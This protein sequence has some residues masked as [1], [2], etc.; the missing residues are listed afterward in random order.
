[1]CGVLELGCWICGYDDFLLR[2]AAD[3]DFVHSLFDKLLDI[4]LV[5]AEQYYSVLGPYIDLTTSGDDFGSQNGPLLSPAMFESLIA[6]Y[7]S[8]RIKRTKEL[9][10]CYFWHH[11]CGSVVELL[12]QIIGN[13]SRFHD[14]ETDCPII[15][16]M[17][18]DLQQLSK[19]QLIALVRELLKRIDQLEKRVT[20]LEAENARLKKNSSNSSKPPSSDIVKPKTVKSHCKRKRKRGGQFG[21]RRHVRAAFGS[22]Q[23]DEVIEYELE[24]TTGLRPLNDWRVIQQIELVDRPFVVTEHRARR[25][26]C[27]RTGKIIRATLPAEVV[28]AGLL[29]PRLSAL[30]AYQKGACHM[31]YSTIQTFLRDVFSISVSTGQLAKLMHKA[32]RALA[33]GYQELADALPDEPHVGADETG[34]KDNGRGLW[35]WCFRPGEFTLFKIAASRGSDVLKAVLGETF[36]GV[37]G[38]DYFSAYRKYMADAGATVQFCLAHLIREVRF[39]TTQADK[40]L[41]NWGQKL[42]TELR[43]LFATLHRRAQMTTKGFAQ[44]MDRI[45]RQFLRLVRRPPDRLEARPLARRFRKHGNSYFTFLTTP[46]AEPTNNLTEQAIR[47]VVI[48]RKITQGTRGDRGQRWCERIWTMLATCAQQDRSAFAFLVDSIKAHWSDRPAPSL[49]PVKL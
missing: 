8:E 28:R 33:G 42:L 29:G 35:T 24:N 44:T 34:H 22:E 15:P 27:R 49:L 23:I 40:V 4:Q 21:H 47:F 11:S 20:E 37:V 45:R 10:Q 5:V 16:W 25:Y 41:A 6:P 36:D 13:H 1:M 7:F 19:P 14:A 18:D 46:G 31:S 17:T 26:R 12:D 30:A 39:L 48:D 2:L 3:T 32:S 9:A 43:N 38:C